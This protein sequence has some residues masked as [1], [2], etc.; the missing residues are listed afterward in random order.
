M[1]QLI[2]QLFCEHHYIC[3]R[4]EIGLETYYFRECQKCGKLKV[5][6]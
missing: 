2:K 4:R 5:Y 6:K 3:Y 1:K